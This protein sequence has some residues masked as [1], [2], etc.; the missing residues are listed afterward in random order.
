MPETVTELQPDFSEPGADATAWGVTAKALEAAEV[1]W[2]TSVRP[3]SV[4]LM[5]SYAARERDIFRRVRIPTS[6]PYLFTGLKVA[7]VLAMIGAIVG[8]Y[9][10]GS[11]DAL[12][13][14]IRRSAGI[15]AF[16]EAWAAIFVA[17]L[18]GIA[19]YGAVALA[20][21]VVLSWHPSVRGG[22][23]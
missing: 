9:F 2:L 6:L 5:R 21:R 13:I 18:L 4:E 12:G 7:T 8:D 14:Q 3:E 11:Q 22:R 23:E 15:F 16:E 20:E 1:Y 19:F 10:G 17:S